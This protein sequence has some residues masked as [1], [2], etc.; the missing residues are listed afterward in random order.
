MG[1]WMFF[2]FGGQHSKKTLSGAPSSL[3]LLW[4]PGGP[5]QGSGGLQKTS[6]HL[7]EGPRRPSGGVSD[8]LW[9]PSDA[10]FPGFR[11]RSARK[12][13][14]NL[15]TQCRLTVA[16]VGARG[17]S[18]IELVRVFFF[19]NRFSGGGFS[20]DPGVQGGRTWVKYNVA[21][22]PGPH[23]P[24]SSLLHILAPPP[25]EPAFWRG[26]GHHPRQGCRTLGGADPLL[27]PIFVGAGGW[28]PRGGIRDT[29]RG[30]S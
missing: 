13:S 5:P 9:R 23:A 24:T 29:S 25:P 22:S 16:A 10:L 21:P 12:S 28:G 6:G 30:H 7:P 19:P 4:G 11:G 26:S 8:G 3:G 15:V 18:P 20:L 2:I 14:K 1:L 17:R 27:G